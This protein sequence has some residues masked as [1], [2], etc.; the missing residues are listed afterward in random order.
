MSEE[1]RYQQNKSCDLKSYLAYLNLKSH[2]LTWVYICELLGIVGDQI[3]EGEVFIELESVVDAADVE[4]S[5]K[6]AEKDK[7]KESGV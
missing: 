4:K 3:R 5:D 2:Y 7:H 6:G 1:V